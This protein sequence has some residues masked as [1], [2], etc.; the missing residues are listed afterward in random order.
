MSVLMTALERALYDL[1]VRH[2][3]A[4]SLKALRR[5][6]DHELRDLGYS[7]GMLAD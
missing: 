2:N 1:R 6:S 3:Q 7:R 5:L 4:V